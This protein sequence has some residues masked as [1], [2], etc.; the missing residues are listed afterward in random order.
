MAQKQRLLAERKEL[1]DNLSHEMKTPLGV[2]RAYAEGMQDEKNEVK[3]QN[4]AEVIIAETERMSS[5]SP[6]CL[7]CL[8]WKAGQ[9]SFARNV[10]IL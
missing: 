2:I 8:H 7:I 1:V 9:H 5:L 10:L 6:L 4:Y 3:R